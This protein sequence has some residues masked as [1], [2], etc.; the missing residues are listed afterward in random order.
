MLPNKFPPRF[1]N[2]AFLSSPKIGDIFSDRINTSLLFL[3]YRLPSPSSNTV[4]LVNERSNA[5]FVS[6]DGLSAL[7][8]I[9]CTI[10]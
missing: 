3:P 2:N 7:Q 1:G 9:S 8:I 5:T 6:R 10:L 4:L